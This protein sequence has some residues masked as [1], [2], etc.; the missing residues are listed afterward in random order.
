VS[1]KIL[2]NRIGDTLAENSATTAKISHATKEN[3][4]GPWRIN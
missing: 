3:V 1:S 2:P 4:F